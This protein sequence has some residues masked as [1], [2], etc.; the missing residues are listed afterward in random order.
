MT[1]GIV[2]RNLLTAGSSGNGEAVN[3]ILNVRVGEIKN[4]S[5]AHEAHV[6]TQMFV[7][8]F[9]LV[10]PTSGKVYEPVLMGSYSCRQQRSQVD[11]DGDIWR[12]PDFTPS[13]FQLCLQS[14]MDKVDLFLTRA[15]VQKQHVQVTYTALRCI[16]N[17]L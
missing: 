5:P 10:C 9:A 14:V 4:N 3:D 17:V 16:R 11:R 7:K 12:D 6:T 1:N 15:F 13:D 2:I 8:T